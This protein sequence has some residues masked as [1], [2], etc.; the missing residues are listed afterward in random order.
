MI[1][2]TLTLLLLLAAPPSRPSYFESS[3]FLE[4][5]VRMAR[6]Q[7]K[8][9]AELLRHLL[10]ERGDRAERPQAL[11]LLGL[12]L[13][14]ERA[15][16][17]AERLFAE[18]L[19]VY[20]ELRDDHLYLRGKALYEWGNLLEASRVLAAVDEAGPRAEEARLLRARALYAATDFE[21]LRHW[22]EEVRARDG[23]LEPE[24]T[25][26]LG[27]A[28]HHQHDVYGAYQAWREV[29][30]EA[31]A[32]RFAGPALRHMA[33]LRIG[34]RHLLSKDEQAAVSSLSGLLARDRIGD[35]LESLE[36]RLARGGRSIEFRA[37]LAYAR[38]R[39]A[40][41][42]GR[43]QTA[44]AHFDRAFRL[45]PSRASELRA[46][47]MLHHARALERL[48]Q[49]GPAL[50]AYEELARRYPERPEAEEA[51]FQAGEMQLHRRE[52]A[53]AKERFRELLLKNPVTR[54]R[55]RSLW[56]L[57]WAERRLGQYDE[58]QPFFSALTKMS[59]SADLAAA[60]LYWLAK[61][62]ADRGDTETARG[63]FRQVLARH[64]LSYYAALAEDQLAE[65]LPSDAKGAAAQPPPE[66]LPPLIAQ[67][68]E[69]LRLGLLAKAREAL[70]SFQRRTRPKERALGERTLRSIARL[71]D[72][73][74]RSTEARKVREAYAREY[75]H[76]LT[77]DEWVEAARRAHPLRYEA[78]IV[79][80]AE[81]FE[82]SPALLFALVR[83][84][85]AFVAEAVS[86]MNAYGLAQLILPTAREVAGRLRAGKVSPGRL[87]SDPAFN[88][89]LGAAYL[90]G[91]L[92]HFEGSEALALAGYNAGPHAVSSWMAYRVR[93]IT[94]LPE[95]GKGVGLLP[96]PDELVEEIPVAETRGY[97]KA[98]LARAR[99]YARLYPVLAPAPPTVTAPTV[100]GRVPYDLAGPDREL[101]WS[102]RAPGG[103]PPGLVRP[104]V[105]LSRS[106]RL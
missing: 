101:V 104:R 2:G 77:P 26:L 81:E 99:S 60:S 63:A 32:E 100:D 31:P 89:R 37:Q 87:V 68:E 22:L 92:D 19:D 3:P 14:A 17:E 76:A 11:Y 51:L 85:S 43:S 33:E 95:T 62:E 86:P 72:E 40:E 34:Q 75:P 82:L 88:V 4:A 96:R 48:G 45:A 9:A 61:T 25:Y 18:L 24:L 58:A 10:A 84:E 20:P 73:A 67:A 53:L 41:S 5:Q 52:Y 71:Y 46:R 56:A 27:H 16:P 105:V 8:E 90:R 70:D 55:P 35:A 57:G 21:T 23:Q 39:L 42:Q 103:E 78:E 93:R 29:W 80:A 30:R 91:L 50:A 49:S 106:E 6:G 102:E 44:A 36:G 69:Y 47:A 97:V 79:R 12:C 64:P 65:A 7:T 13:L 54:Y 38:G 28:R 66:A 94:G 15:Y 1:A 83:T 98:V 59:L 74:G